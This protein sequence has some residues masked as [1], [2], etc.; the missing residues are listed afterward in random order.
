MV[1]TWQG[2]SLN[3]RRFLVATGILTIT[4]L[5]GMQFQVSSQ[6]DMSETYP[7][8]FRG[9]TCT[10]ETDSLLIG[11]SAYL[12]P[13][14]YE[15]PQ[16]AMSALTVPILCGKV[17]GPGI[18][19]VTIDLLYPEAIR[20]KPLA[21]RLVKFKEKGAERELFSVPAQP[22]RSGTI[23]QALTLDEPGQYV[24]Y[25]EGKGIDNEDFSL[26]MPIRIGTEWWE[27]LL[28]YWPLLLLSVSAYF[29]YNFRKIVG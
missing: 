19:D 16:D 22:Y 10:I 15:I 7:K 9:G 4:V 28:P 11:F 26:E 3:V 29:F 5:I 14:D 21:L 25:L 20:D 12:I 2:L 27:E 13:R 6:G 23:T 17:P 8:G 18:L 1:E 24:L